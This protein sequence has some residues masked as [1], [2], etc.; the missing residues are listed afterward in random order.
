VDTPTERVDVFDVDQETGVWTN[1][2]PHAFLDSV[3]GYPD[4]MA[5]DEED[6]LWIAL[7]GS[8]AVAH[9]DAE[10]RLVEII[11]V[12][13]ISQ[14][15]ACTFGGANRDILY[16]TT[17]RQGLHD[18]AEPFAGAVFAFATSTRGPVEFTFGRQ[19]VQ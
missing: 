4:G 9:Y 15:S 2:R 8:G 11:D 17:S 13:G 18:S 1:R 14:S 5:I 3:A 7:W 12:P 16:V 6:G 19:A 10:A